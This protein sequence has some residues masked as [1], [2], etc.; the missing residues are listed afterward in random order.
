MIKLLY[1]I[2]ADSPDNVL[3]FVG[4]GDIYSVAK[5]LCEKP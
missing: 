2:T 3:L 4:A 5:A 1:A